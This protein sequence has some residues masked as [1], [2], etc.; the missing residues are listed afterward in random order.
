[1]SNELT[2]PRCVEERKS[3][4]PADRRH[5]IDERNR[6]RRMMDAIESRWCNSSRDADRMH[7]LMDHCQAELDILNAELGLA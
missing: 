1:M 7:R 4:N 3:M 5:R 2:A 6:I